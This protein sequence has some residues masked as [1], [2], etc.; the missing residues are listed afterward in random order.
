MMNNLNYILKYNILYKKEFNS[1]NTS[2]TALFRS[3]L[4]KLHESVYET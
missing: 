2:S 1:K 4:G 3:D